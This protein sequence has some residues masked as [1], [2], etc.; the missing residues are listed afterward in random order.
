VSGGDQETDSR[1]RE[2]LGDSGRLRG[3]SGELVLDHLDATLE[4]SDLGADLG[5]SGT[6][7]IGDLA[8]GVLDLGPGRGDGVVSS[9]GDEDSE[10]AE[11]AAQGV[12]AGG[13]FGEP[14]GA[15]AMQG[16]EGLLGDGLDRDGADLIVAVGLEHALGV[17]AVGLVAANVGAH[18][19]RRQQ[20]R[21]VAEGADAARPEVRRATGLHDDGGRRQLCE[22]E[23]ELRARVPLLS[24][25]LPRVMGDGD[26][27][28]GLCQIDRDESIFRHGWA[29]SFAYQQATL[30][31]AS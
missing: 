1:D 9:E 25:H 3:E 22:G 30:A 28:D 19:V 29:P 21:L 17:G 4:V 13:A 16:G 7:R 23:R 31:L 12:D 24:G 8:L 20:N 14:A 2:E 11:Q 5:E 18:G 6:E 15:D 27:E 10:L 26:L